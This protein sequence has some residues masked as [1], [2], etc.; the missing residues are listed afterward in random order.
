MYFSTI[1]V[2]I[3]L[4]LVFSVFSEMELESQLSWIFWLAISIQHLVR[5][6]LYGESSR[7]RWVVSESTFSSINLI[8]LIILIRRCFRGRKFGLEWHGWSLFT[9][10]IYTTIWWIDWYDDWS[11]TFNHVCLINVYL[12]VSVIYKYIYIYKCLCNTSSFIS[13][14]FYMMFFLIGTLTWKVSPLKWSLVW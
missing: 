2:F 6:Y 1:F 8:F 4:V 13:F 10:G 11:G 14:Y 9:I 5:L 12:F 3:L 7:L